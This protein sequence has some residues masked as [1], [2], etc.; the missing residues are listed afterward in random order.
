MKKIFLKLTFLVIVLAFNSCSQE[1]IDGDVSSLNSVTSG[2]FDKIFDVS[3]DNS[4]LVRIT[5]LGEGMSKS[6]VTLGHGTDEP[7]TV[8]PG[9]SVSHNYPEGSYTVTI[10][11]FDLAGNS[12]TNTYPLQIVYRAPENVSVNANVA[13]HDVTVSA[14]ADYANGFLV[15]FGDVANETPTSMAVGQTLP[16][17]TYASA[18]NYTITVVALSG[19]AATTTETVN[20]LIYNPY[21]LP[22][23]YE[24]PFQ[25]Y[26]IGGTFGGVNVSKVANPFSGGINTSANVWQYTKTN[27]AA[28]WSGTWTPLAAP[29]GTPIN[30]DNGSKIKVMV[31][32][33][34]AGKN[35]N[36]EIEQG[37]NGVSNKIL[38]MPV[39]VANQWTE[40]EF[41][42]GTFGIPAGTTFKQLVFRY[43][44]IADGFGEV[45][46][47]DNVTQS[48]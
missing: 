9:A 1:G 36:V 17:H 26:G 18:G 31:Y 23:T 19:G 15:Y 45:I 44:D 5:P 42:F 34:E 46:Y 39:P 20:V 38:K 11:S 22:I 14:T 35:L 4:G 10:E 8:F 48:N 32:A 24:D 12:T 2:N 13:G 21:S 3:N 33:T 40:I 16:A 27:G 25:N 47:I 41:D 30:I 37:S 6:V 29:N 7:T 43:N 28:S